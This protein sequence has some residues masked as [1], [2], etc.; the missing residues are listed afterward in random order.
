MRSKQLWRVY[1]KQLNRIHWKE[2]GTNGI[3]NIDMLGL[4]RERSNRTQLVSIRNQMLKSTKARKIKRWQWKR[5]IWGVRR[6]HK[7]QPCK[8]K[9][10][11]HLQEQGRKVD[12][13][14]SVVLG[15]E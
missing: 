5:D 8:S 2:S 10:Q 4:H 11:K 15:G 1:I 13:A 14:E 9:D 12:A 7:W 3:W 6:G